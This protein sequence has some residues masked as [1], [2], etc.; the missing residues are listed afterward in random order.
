MTLIPAHLEQFLQLKTGDPDF[1]P[2]FLSVAG[3]QG[4]SEA[5]GRSR[6][7]RPSVLATLL[8]AQPE[9]ALTLAVICHCRGIS[10]QKPMFSQ[11]GNDDE[12]SSKY[13]PPNKGTDK[14][15]TFWPLG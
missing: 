2:T 3:G 14:K 10:L 7:R 1:T 6:S 15:S 9:P 8:A 11:G 13:L 12:T 5:G 4:V